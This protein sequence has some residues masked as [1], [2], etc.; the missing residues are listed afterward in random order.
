[1]EDNK[2]D[3]SIIIPHHNTPDLLKR[4]L[5]SIPDDRR[6]QVIVVDDN[7]NPEIVNFPDL[8]NHGRTNTTVVLTKEGRGAGYA[9]NVG[10]SL[11]QGK[12]LVFSDSDDFF[13]PNLLET[14]DQYKESKSEMILFKARSVDSETLE[15]ANR[16]E[17]INKRIDE[18]LNGKITPKEASLLVHSPWCRMVK[19][20]FVE[21]HQIRYD[22]V[23]CENDTMFTTKCG[24]LSKRIEVS[25]NVLYVCTYRK[26][27]LWDARKT[28][29]E[30]YLT[31]I[32]VQ[33]NRN[34]YVSQYGYEQ[35]PIIG[36]VVRAW[37]L[38][39]KTFFRALG[40][41]LSERALFQGVGYYFNKL[42]NQTY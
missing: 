9:R 7:S 34:K 17:N 39:L 10:L 19:R 11:A 38:G 18:A 26:G 41:T 3:Y 28:N 35:I 6:I 12:W 21:E 29:P 42:R 33:I 14:L 24:C 36:F 15:P 5:N 32:K 25:P 23:M 4:C 8:Q 40:I 31:R 1:M 22:E 13:E 20:S 37:A 2:I 27:S 30:N 16:N